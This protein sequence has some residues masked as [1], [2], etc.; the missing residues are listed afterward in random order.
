MKTC[1]E[2]ETV[3]AIQDVK[4]KTRSA[5]NVVKTKLTPRVFRPSILIFLVCFVHVFL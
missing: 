2:D 3:D 4:I 1:N 5:L